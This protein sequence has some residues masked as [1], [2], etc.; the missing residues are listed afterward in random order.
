MYTYVHMCTS[1]YMYAHKCTHI[2]LKMRGNYLHMYVN[3]IQPESY[4]AVK[5]NLT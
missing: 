3:A 1:L 5:A 4:E 2:I